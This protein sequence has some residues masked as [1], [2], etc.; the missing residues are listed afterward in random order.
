MRSHS[1]TYALILHCPS[2]ESIEVGS[3]GKLTLKQGYY[4]YVGSAF[5]PGGVRA[6]VR[7]H[8]KRDK[9]L[10]W[11]IDYARGIMPLIEVWYSHESEIREHE[12][13][14]VLSA[15]QGI[16]S[17]KGF[18]SSDCGCGSHFFHVTARPDVS[19]FCCQVSQRIEMV[20]HPV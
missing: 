16:D 5:G 19:M 2:D 10:H 4:I 15:D 12:W 3:L 17:I 18:G 14:K 20:R 7:R 1:G 6:R 8:Y 11:H 9:V 13:A